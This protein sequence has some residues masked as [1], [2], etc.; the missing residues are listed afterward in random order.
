MPS[1]DVHPPVITILGPTAVG[2]SEISLALALGL[3]GEI[4]SADSRLLYRGMDIGTDKPSIETQA[5]V[6]H[7]LV[8]VADPDER[9]S[10]AQFIA[11][12]REAMRDVWARGRL[13]IVVG[14]TGQYIRALIEGWQ[15][16][17]V[18]PDPELRKELERLAEE[19]GPLGLHDRLT[20][21]DPVGASEIDP[22]NVR[23][24][25]RALEVIRGSGLAFSEQKTR[26]APPYTN[27]II[28]LSRPRPELYARID[29]RIDDMI[30]R[31]FVGEVRSLLDQGC[32]CDLAS[33]SAIGYQEVC[34]YL[35]GDYDL[36]TAVRLM[37]KRSRQLVRRQANWFKLDDPEISWHRVES[38]LVEILV[39]EVREFLSAPP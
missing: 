10:L 28:G 29:Q 35:R 22:R 26:L 19:I 31:G 12:A 38:G 17:K 5:R 11:A 9:W 24:T 8:D 1:A 32:R 23:R 25:I 27:K 15:V 34:G 2:K 14:G 18:E 13:P 7:H 21:L 3:T 6:T 33:F 37:K 36:E 30:E 16:P 39:Q 20:A 4:I